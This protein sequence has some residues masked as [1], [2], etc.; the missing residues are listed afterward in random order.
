M[1]WREKLLF[2]VANPNVAYILMI[3]GIYG[4]IAELKSPSFGGAGILG[5]ICL[6]LGLFALSVLEPSVAGLALIL[7]GVGF[8]IGELFA[9]THGLLT[10]GGIVAFTIGSLI[11]FPESSGL[12][13]S[14]PLIA[15]VVISLVGFFVFVLGAIVKGQKRKVV[16]GAQGLIGQVGQV[17]RKLDPVGIVFADGTLW[18]AESAEGA[19]EVG[20]R[21]E[22][23][24]VNGLRLRVRAAPGPPG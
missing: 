6:V 19:V 12:Q 17:R 3:L 9:P 2:P 18:T 7:V 20:E 24:E 13:V 11:L 4:L 21:V 16:T 22:I 23:M 10:V 15:G 1:T 14:R 8:L 5:A